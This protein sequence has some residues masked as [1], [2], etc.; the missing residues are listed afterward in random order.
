[1][2]MLSRKRPAHHPPI[3]RAGQPIVIFVTAV[4]SNE[5]PLLA[6]QAMHEM[7]K[8]AWTQSTAWQ[9]GN[10]MIMPDHVHFFCV[11]ATWP[12]TS[13]RMWVKFWKGRVTK[14]M[15]ASVSIWQRDFWDTQIRDRDHYHEKRSYVDMNPVRRGF[16]TQPEE[17]PY[18]GCLHTIVWR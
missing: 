7:I 11:P 3:E 9:I 15:G 10:Y 5:Q 8:L 6:N 2:D 14:I 17:W 1:M 16:V 12:P 13:L 4:T 18:R